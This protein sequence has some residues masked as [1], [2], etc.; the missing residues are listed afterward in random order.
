MFPSQKV[1]NIQQFGAKDE[2]A[3]SHCKTGGSKFR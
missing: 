1:G 3:A 2:L